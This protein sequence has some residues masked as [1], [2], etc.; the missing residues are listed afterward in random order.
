[1]GREVLTPKKATLQ[2]FSNPNSAKKKHQKA[3]WFYKAQH[4]VY[5]IRIHFVGEN[6]IRTDHGVKRTRGVQGGFRF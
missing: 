4:L 2:G 3:T 5:C 1:V 6:A